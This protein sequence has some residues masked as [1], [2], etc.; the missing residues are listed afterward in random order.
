MPVYKAAPFDQA[1]N[2][3]KKLDIKEVRL[4]KLL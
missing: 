2:I 4:Y 3:T 1:F